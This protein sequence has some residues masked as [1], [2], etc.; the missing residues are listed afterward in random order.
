M[1]LLSRLLG[2]LKRESMPLVNDPSGDS[3]EDAYSA[4]YDAEDTGKPNPY[5]AGTHQYDAWVKGELKRQSD[6]M[7]IW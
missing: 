4:G 7:T 5:R 3:A 1:N 2:I 6:E